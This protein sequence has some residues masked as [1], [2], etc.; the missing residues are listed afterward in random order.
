MNNIQILELSQYKA[1]E[2]VEST[3][4]EWVEY[5]DENNHYR[6]L[7]D[8]YRNSATNNA[9]INNI[10]RLI[11][12]R[13]LHAIDAARKPSQYAAM[14]SLLSS[15]DLRKVCIELYMLGAGH[16]QVHYDDKH[17]KV[18]KIYHIETEYIR[19]EKCNEDGDI[20]GYYY[21]DNWE[22]V[23]KYPP[24]RIPAFGTSKEKIEI[25]CIKPYSVGMKYFGEVAYQGGLPYAVLE[26]EIADFL[27][28]DVQNK[29]SG[30]K[31]VNFNN[32]IPAEQQQEDISRKVISKLTGSTGQKVI[33]AFNNNAESKTT[34][35][36][37]PLDDAPQH[38]EYLS[39]EAEQKILISHNVISPMLVGVVTD[40]QG[41]S[42]NA[43]EIEISAKYFHN[44][45]IRPFQDLIIDALDRIFAFNDISLDLFFR[46]LNLL[47]EL[48]VEEQKEEE[49]ATV[50]MSSQL[51]DLLAEFGEDEDE[52]WELLDSRE[53]NYDEEEELD[54]QVLEWEKSMQPK[55]SLLSKLYNLVSTGTA[56]GNAS[57]EQ[58]KQVKDKF[59]KVRYKYTGNPNPERDFCKAMMARKNRIFRKE[60]IDMMGSKIVNA[61]FG[62]FGADTY[63]IFKYKGGPRCHH[64]WERRTYVSATRSVD[65]NSP[66]ATTI[67]T[68]AAEVKGYTVRNPFEVSIYPNNLPLKGFS[69]NNKNLPSDVR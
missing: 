33:V 17:T 67:G 30:T 35:D 23:R 48:E 57:S 9:V 26:E 49:E 42:S 6:W 60:D 68:R 7:I 66:N 2:A 41:F 64:K 8:R 44:I 1:P 20:T 5:G 12:G 36:D 22:D 43:D 13:G 47:Q 21:S 65:V 61:G 28:N 31:V 56:R 50:N 53:V 18:I 45:A 27:I 3:R 46:R 10:G 38:Y 62:E 58:D 29:F 40:N 55:T 15:E 14:K 24:R 69:P 54:A 51:E 16:F 19:P 39:K 34:I 63:D 4:N 32:G 11:Y 25:Y 59:F 52:D 37:I